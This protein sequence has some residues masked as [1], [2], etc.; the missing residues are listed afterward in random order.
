MAGL[1]LRH[2]DMTTWI[3]NV[4]LMLYCIAS[5]FTR[6]SIYSKYVFDVTIMRSRIQNK[7][8]RNSGSASVSVLPSVSLSVFNM[9]F[10]HYNLSM[11]F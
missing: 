8:T 11:D 5:S 6:V 10:K 7:F 4:L 3:Y 9:D 1:A 2:L